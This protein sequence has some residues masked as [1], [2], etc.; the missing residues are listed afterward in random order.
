MEPETKI[1]TLPGI[2]EYGEGEPVEIWLRGNGR[3]VIR[4]WNECGNNHTDVDL[5]DLLDWCRSNPEKVIDD[6]N[7][8][9]ITPISSSERNK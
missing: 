1:A 6:R 5:F 9:G 4:A 7:D 2:R 3:V 8:L